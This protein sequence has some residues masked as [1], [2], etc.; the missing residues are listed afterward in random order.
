MQVDLE[1]SAGSAKSKNSSFDPLPSLPSRPAPQFS[2]KKE[3]LL[4]PNSSGPSHL[5]LLLA[6]Q[7]AILFSLPLEIGC[8]FQL[9]LAIT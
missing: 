9:K 2:H 6:S 7:T 8:R 3:I 4:C 1:Q 5:S